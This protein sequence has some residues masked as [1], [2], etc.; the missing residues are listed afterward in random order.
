MRHTNLHFDFAIDITVIV[1]LNQIMSSPAGH[2]QPDD[3]SSRTVP[4]WFQEHQQTRFED[5]SKRRLRWL[6]AKS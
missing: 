6:R 2:V 4:R 3:L 1:D 5:R